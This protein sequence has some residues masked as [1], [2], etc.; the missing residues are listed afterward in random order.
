MLQDILKRIHSDLAG[1]NLDPEVC[2]AVRLGTPA[3]DSIVPSPAPIGPEED[4]IDELLA[5]LGFEYVDAR[6]DVVHRT[7]EM[8]SGKHHNVS[9]ASAYTN[10]QMFP[11][12]LVF[13]TR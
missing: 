8:G 4:A 5:N 6:G 1:S 2:L 12:C 7:I 3:A 10:A 11:D 9:A 13:W